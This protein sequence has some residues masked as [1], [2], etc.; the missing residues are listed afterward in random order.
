MVQ[1]KIFVTSAIMVALLSTAVKTTAQN[2]WQ[3]WNSLNVSASVTKKLTAQIGHTRAFNMSNKFAP[4]FSQTLLQM[5]YDHSKEWDFSGGVQF[6][7]PAN[8]TTGTRTRL[9]I[10]A[11]Y[12]KRLEQF[13]WTNSLRLETNS[14]NENRFRQRI[15]LSTRLGLR[16]RLDFLK[17]SPSVMYSLFYNIGGNPIRYYDENKVLLARQTPDGFHRGRLTLSVN[18][19]VSDML[20]VS[21]FYMR[22]HEFN[23]LTPDNRKMNV[24][25]P[26]RNR[27]LRPFD[28]FNV[29]GISLNVS[30]DDLITQ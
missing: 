11:A 1:T 25:D 3:N 8:T 14:A 16:K 24:F 12:T 20:R 5:S 7:K 21:V 22:Q 29:L 2:E 15:I 27:I 28:N 23:L 30:L 4:T 17:L 6:I 19:K 9:F 18:S 26:V 10:R 13:N